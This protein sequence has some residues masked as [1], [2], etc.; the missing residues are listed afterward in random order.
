[1][2]EALDA[3]RSR[4][5]VRAMSA[6]L[7]SVSTPQPSLESAARLAEEAALGGLAAGC[8][9]MITNPLDIARVRLQLRREAEGVGGPL[10]VITRAVREEGPVVLTK[11][12]GFSV[13]YNVVLNSTRFAAFHALSDAHECGM[14]A[15]VSGMIAGTVAGIISSPLAKARTLQQRALLGAGANVSASQT[16]LTSPFHGSLSW[17]V[18]NG[19]HTGII[20]S[21]YASSKSFLTDALPSAPAPVIHVAASL[22]AALISCIVM[23]PVDVIATRMYNSALSAH[24]AAGGAAVYSSPMACLVTTVAKEGYIGLYR[25]LSANI[26]RIMPH[27]VLTFTL[28]ELFRS[29]LRRREPAG[30]AV[31]TAC[32]P[33]EAPPALL[34]ESDASGAPPLPLF[35]D[36]FDFP[37]QPIDEPAMS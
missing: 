35:V 25:G 23:N 28:M 27:T 2:L 30:S 37:V 32:G 22:Q 34:S 16:F 20:F 7:P 15:P 29:C 18:R 10:R 4:T 9:A 8:A 33:R 6:R 26:M 21:V 13:A 36:P 24:T 5:W 11:G 31:Q 3:R 14:P 19:G 1:M 17:G 12:L